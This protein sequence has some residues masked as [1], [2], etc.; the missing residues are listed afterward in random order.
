MPVRRWEVEPEPEAPP[1]VQV[2]QPEDAPWTWEQTVRRD[3]ATPPP[4]PPEDSKLRKRL[5]IKTG[6]A[7]AKGAGWVWVGLV[8][9]LLLYGC[10]KAM[11]RSSR[12]VPEWDG[13]LPPE[14]RRFVDE[15]N[16][17]RVERGREFQRR[18]EEETRAI[19]RR[20]RQAAAR[21]RRAEQDRLRREA[22]EARALRMRLVRVP[23]PRLAK[24]QAVLAS[25][26]GV[27]SRLENT[28]GM[29]FVLIP[30]GTF[31]MGSPEREAGRDP[32]EVLHAVTLTKPYYVQIGEVTNA[33]FRHFRERHQSDS[34]AGLEGFDRYDRPVT[35]VGWHA[36]NQ[37]CAWLS[38]RE[39]ARTYRLPTEAEWEHA[40]RAGS[41][42][43]FPW[44]PSESD[45]HL[46]AN[47]ADLTAKH[48]MP[49]RM[50]ERVEADPRWRW[51]LHSD[52]HL[53]PTRPGTFREN[54][55]GLYDMI[56]NVFEWCA[57]WAGP[58]DPANATDPAGPEE[59]ELRII[60]GGAADAAPHKCRSAWRGGMRPIKSSP[61]LG[62]RVVL[63]VE[64]AKR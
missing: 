15:D 9:F 35:S 38:K 42:T 22:E 51:I 47:G 11:S 32:G 60:R 63:E 49:Y 10:G 24:E 52:G 3:T 41:N 33:Q 45:M 25:E 6:R 12:H 18:S 53:E 21:A 28:L 39:P 46:H 30:A 54:T 31:Y 50:R 27:P 20:R 2:G 1:P 44:G 40:C 64:T 16:P 13:S 43:S 19:E 17:R 7:K 26:L 55:W 4:L 62:F 23:W 58:Y 5:A 36:A 48:D 29:R 61:N 8:I 59:G 57:D 37:F 34:P 56:G 14:M